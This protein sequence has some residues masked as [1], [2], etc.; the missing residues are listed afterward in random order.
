MHYPLMFTFRDAVS[1]EGFLAG[2]TITGRALMVPEEDGSWW[3]YGVRPGA[4][5]EGGKAPEEAY[6]KFRNTYKAALFDAAAESPT[7]DAFRRQVEAFFYQPDNQE[8]TR[9]ETAFRAMRE[10]RSP[11]EGPLSSL[12]RQDPQTR[13]A[14]IS[15]TRLDCVGEQRYVPSDNVPDTYSLAEAA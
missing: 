14:Q 12:P 11:A 2:V 15:V 10:G 1:G 5:A 13:P 9:W 6:L 8:E 3:L 7:Y 4:I